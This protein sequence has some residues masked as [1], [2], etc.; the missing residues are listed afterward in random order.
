[1]ES[2]YWG[3][4]EAQPLAIA[5]KKDKKK[6]VGS[7]DF[8]KKGKIMSMDEKKEQVESRLAVRYRRPRTHGKGRVDG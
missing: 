3:E 6:D 2:C 1:M 7:R 4:A 8:K 5:W